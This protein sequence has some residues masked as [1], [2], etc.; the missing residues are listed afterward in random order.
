MPDGE[1]ERMVCSEDPFPYIIFVQHLGNV[2]L[3]R[4]P[5]ILTGGRLEHTFG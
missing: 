1:S 2:W 4:N 3:D 5:Q